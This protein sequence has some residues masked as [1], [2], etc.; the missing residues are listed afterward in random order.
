MHI[1][2]LSRTKRR[3]IFALSVLLFCVGVPALVFYAIG[4]RLD[5]ENPDKNFRAVGGLY[6]SAEVD[7]LSIYVDDDPAEDMRVFLNAAYIQNIDEGMHQVHVQ[8]EDVAT[9]IKRLPVF[10]HFVTEARSF[11][12]P[13]ATQ[14]RL[15]TPYVTNAGES[16]VSPLAT[17]TFAFA[18]TTN[19]FYATS[20]YATSSYTVSLEHTYLAQLFASTTE[21]RRARMDQERLSEK[22]FYFPNE[23]TTSTSTLLTATTT[24]THSDIV[25]Y[26]KDD[27]VYAKYEGREGQEPYYF[28]VTY[29]GASSTATQYGEHVYEG[30]V[31]ELASSTDFT[32]PDLVG[33]QLCRAEIRI[34][35]KWQSVQ[36]FDFMPGSEHLVLMQLQDGVYVVEIDDRSW[37]NVQLLYPGDY[38]EVLIDSGSIFIK[39]G[40]YILEVF[41]ELQ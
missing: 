5:L 6:I 33:V 21:T 41:T 22:R 19:S 37:Q 16:V 23:A 4:Y 40:E 32:N 10:A 2:P 13:T 9:W 20:S 15:V 7:D 3:I 36:Y 27:D 11:N 30:L 31:T 39:D 26:K 38:L 29:T 25:L 12:M 18:S 14:I 35:R 34:D 8:G 17:S 28:C 24:K 1:D